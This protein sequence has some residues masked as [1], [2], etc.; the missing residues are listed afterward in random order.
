MEF[1]CLGQAHKVICT[2]QCVRFAQ[3]NFLVLARNLG[4]AAAFAGDGDPQSAEMEER[5]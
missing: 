5:D 1:I 2:S 4:S 3:R